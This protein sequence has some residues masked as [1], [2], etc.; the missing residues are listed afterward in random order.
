MMVGVTC[1]FCGTVVEAPD[2]AA[3][4]GAFLAHVRAAHAEFPY[5][6]IAVRNYAAATQRLSGGTEHLTDIGDVVVARVTEDRIDDWLDFFDHDAFAGNP[7]WAACY[8]AEPHRVAAG[9]APEDVEPT[10]WRE[11][12]DYM[13][14]LLRS[15]RSCGYLAYVDGRPAGWVNA[16]RRSE[17]TL[18]RRG[19][20]AEP[21]DS[22]IIGISCF[23]IA[24]PYRR[25]GLATAMLEHVIID[26]RDR[27]AEWIEAYPFNE[28]RDDDAARFRGPR[29]LFEAHGFEPVVRRTHDTVVRRGV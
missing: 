10:T 13:V 26:A 23:I 9:T 24:P 8:C 17:Y 5:P 2:Q 7:A 15:G 6:D 20:D 28:E 11:N 16:S 21:A 12:R 3:F 27:D 14:E 25:H 19:P 29:A 18:Y 22:D 4:E 1:E